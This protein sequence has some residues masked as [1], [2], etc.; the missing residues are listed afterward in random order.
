M[1]W[2]DILYTA[3]ILHTSVEVFVLLLR[4]GVDMYNRC[5]KQ[6]ALQP[7]PAPSHL[8]KQNRMHIKHEQQ[9]IN[10]FTR[11]RDIILIKAFVSHR[12]STWICTRNSVAQFP[13]GSA[14]RKERL[15]L[16]AMK[17]VR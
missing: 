16:I 7:P 1:Q 6:V 5:N 14:E 11:M 8:N 9:L 12:A 13:H 10:Q 4:K 2:D 17:T 3:L 15:N